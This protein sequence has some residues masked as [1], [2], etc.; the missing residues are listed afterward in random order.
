[1]KE[2]MEVIYYALMALAGT[3][4]LWGCVCFCGS[5]QLPFDLQYAAL[6]AGPYFIA[7]LWEEL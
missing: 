6:G 3:W 7:I 4:L 2:V 1:M 5:V